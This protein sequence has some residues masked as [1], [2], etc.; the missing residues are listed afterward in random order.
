MKIW[1][2]AVMPLA[3][4]LLIPLLSFAQELISSEPIPEYNISHEAKFK[5]VVAEMNQQ[6]CPMTGGM[7]WHLTVRID[8]KIYEVHVAPVKFA[9]I[10]EADVRKGD[11]IEIVG[12]KTQF[13]HA[14][15]ILP[16][17]I[18]DGKHDFLFRDEKGK[19][20]W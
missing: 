3:V 19:P 9:K 17:E 12:V 4:W 16:R 18:K 7:D 5:G 13:H 2:L 15:V 11:W 8:N 1:P 10:Y 14:D 20:F 6:I